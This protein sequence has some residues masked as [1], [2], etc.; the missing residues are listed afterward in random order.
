MADQD[1]TAAD[2]VTLGVALLRAEGPASLEVSR[3]C[4]RLGCNLADFEAFDCLELLEA[5]Q[6][7]DV[8][9][10]FPQVLRCHFAD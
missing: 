2:W 9:L 1:V 8:R 6:N 4:Q 7:H 10:C 3:L 5:L